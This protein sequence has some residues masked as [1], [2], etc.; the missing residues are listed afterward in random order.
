MH[1]TLSRVARFTRRHSRKLAVSVRKAVAAGVSFSF[2][3]SP[4]AV[5]F[6]P[7]LAEA[8]ARPA[9]PQVLASAASQCNLQSAQG[10]I[11]HVIYIQFDNVHFTRDNPNVP[12]DLEQ[13]PHLLNFFANNG[14]FSNNHHT[15]LISHTADDIITSL[16]GVYGER[17]GQPVLTASTISIPLIHS[18]LATQLRSPTGRT[19][20]IPSPILL[21]VSS[22]LLARTRRL[23]GC[24]LHAPDATLAPFPSPIWNWKTRTPTSRPCLAPARQK[25]RR[26][27]AVPAKRRKTSLVSL[28]TA[29]R[30]MR[31]VLRETANPTSFRTSPAAT[32]ASTR[33][34]ATST[35]CR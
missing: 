12:S 16:T 14:T 22:L 19:W 25:P 3:L 9:A 35:W 29:Q 5:G 1:R 7:D 23:R 15:P 28:F 8:K 10:A 33:S 13:M 24:L 4:A 31:F 17:H 18:A 32:L 27:P 34:T 11:K 20:S 30:A 2:A 26:R 6:F 21:S